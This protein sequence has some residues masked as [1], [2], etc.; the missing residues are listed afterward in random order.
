MRVCVRVRTR[1]RE[2]EMQRDGVRLREWRDELSVT[3]RQ[4]DRQTDRQ[5]DGRT[6]RRSHTDRQINVCT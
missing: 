4:I 6:E 1:A 2:R 3:D 5:A